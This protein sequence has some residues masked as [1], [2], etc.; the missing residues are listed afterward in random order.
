ML[1]ERY[2]LGALLGVVAVA[3]RQTNAVWVA[4]ILGTAVLNR[5]LERDMQARRLPAE[6][7]LLHVLRASW[8]VSNCIRCSLQP[9]TQR[10]QPPLKGR[11]AHLSIS[12]PHKSHSRMA[13]GGSFTIVPWAFRDSGHLI[14]KVLLP[15]AG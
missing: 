15:H 7:Q 14:S 3:F 8:R 2:H 11:L 13:C 1:H 10:S 6:K 9:Y 4:F 5:A 12:M